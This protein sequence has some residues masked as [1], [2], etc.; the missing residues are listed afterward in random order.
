MLPH[1]GQL[2]HT[3]GPG[4]KNSA[5]NPIATTKAPKSLYVPYPREV[6]MYG[7]VLETRKL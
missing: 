7:V 4:I 3:L 2:A 6:I 1:F 5:Q